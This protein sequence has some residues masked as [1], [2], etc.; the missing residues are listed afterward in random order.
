MQLFNEINHQ[1]VMA[2]RLHRHGGHSNSRGPQRILR[3]LSRHD[4]LTN[5]EIAEM[6]DIRPS[7]VSASIKQLETSQL[8]IRQVSET[9]KRVSTVHL[10]E[11]G[12]DMMDQLST[13]NDQMGERIFSSLSGDEQAQLS[14]LLTKLDAGVNEL[15]TEDDPQLQELRQQMKAIHAQLG[16]GR[17][18]HHHE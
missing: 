6:L 14:E 5:A 11:K 1:P 9:D 15:S 10:T 18:H 2:S 4:G 13:L 3:L 8:I 12:R 7:S 17:E 16:S